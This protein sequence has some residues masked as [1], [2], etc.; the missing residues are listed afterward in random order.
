MSR[1]RVILIAAAVVVIAVLVGLSTINT[2]V[3]VAPVEEP[4]TNA[5]LGH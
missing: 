2:E 3:P 1:T 4:V 5:T